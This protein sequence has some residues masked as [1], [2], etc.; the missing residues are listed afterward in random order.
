MKTGPKWIKA[1][2]LIRKLEKREGVLKM[3]VWP[4]RDPLGDNGIVTERA[5]SRENYFRII[6]L[7][8]MPASRMQ[9]FSTHGLLE[10]IRPIEMLSDGPSL[11]KFSHNDSVNFYDPFGENCSNPCRAAACAAAAAAACGP[12][13][14]VPPPW[15]G[16]IL[17]ASCTAGLA[18]YCCS[19]NPPPLYPPGN[20]N[21]PVNGPYNPG[22]P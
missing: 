1:G 11:Y 17:G 12:V 3:S 7:L 19:D 9:Q 6:S 13:F 18:A 8:Y 20:P 16:R 10:F 4:N 5:Y 14:L 22:Y 2:K 21:D 15:V